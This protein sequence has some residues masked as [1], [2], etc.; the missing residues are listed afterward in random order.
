MT[1]LTFN[2]TTYEFKLVHVTHYG[3]SYNSLHIY[4]D[5]ELTKTRRQCSIVPQCLEECV[6]L[7]RYYDI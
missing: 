7:I 5:G 2:E 6:E 3:D 4:V 1:K